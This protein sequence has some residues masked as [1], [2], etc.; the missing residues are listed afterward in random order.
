MTYVNTLNTSEEQTDRPLRL[1]YY[2]FMCVRKG[3]WQLREWQKQVTQCLG[4][5]KGEGTESS[6][7]HCTQGAR[8]CEP[9][10]LSRHWWHKLP[11][12]LMSRSTLLTYQFNIK[13]LKVV[14]SL[15]RVGKNIDNRRNTRCHNK[16]VFCTKGAVNSQINLRTSQ[17]KFIYNNTLKWN[18]NNC[19]WNIVNQPLCTVTYLFVCLKDSPKGSNL[20]SLGAQKWLEFQHFFQEAFSIPFGLSAAAQP[21]VGHCAPLTT[22]V[23]CYLKEQRFKKCQNSSM[24]KWFVIILECLFLLNS[25]SKYQIKNS[26]LKCFK[27]EINLKKCTKKKNPLKF[28]FPLF[29]TLFSQRILCSGSHNST[30]TPDNPIHSNPDTRVNTVPFRCW[31]WTELLNYI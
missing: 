1:T 18:L 22:E 26:L 16:A 13:M 7:S 14:R 25:I 5:R 2:L 10:R 31:I 28:K 23:Y 12:L 4:N 19:K 20:F 3:E 17:V 27:C 30:L 6:T 15:C 29:Q 11:I 21:W 24:G 9:K 8:P